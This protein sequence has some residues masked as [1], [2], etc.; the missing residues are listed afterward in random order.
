MWN[1]S[2]LY[3]YATNWTY[4]SQIDLFHFTF[5][6][7]KLFYFVFRYVNIYK[8]PSQFDSKSLYPV[9]FTYSLLPPQVTFISMVYPSILVFLI[10][11]RYQLVVCYLF[12]IFPVFTK[13]RLFLNIFISSNA[14]TFL[15]Y[16]FLIL[17]CVRDV[18]PLPGYREIHLCFLL[19]ILW[20]HFLWRRV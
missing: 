11:L 7:Q 2:P 4:S 18:S 17:S 1:S 13:Q 20:L 14:L 6:F 15:L 12:Q 8:V 19:V 16:C 3:G 10:Y 9:S 5:D